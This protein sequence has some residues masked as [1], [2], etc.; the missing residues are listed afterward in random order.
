MST[1]RTESPEKIAKCAEVGRNARRR[2][3]ALAER[4]VEAFN[5]RLRER[6]A[7]AGASASLV[8]NADPPSTAETHRPSQANEG[9]QR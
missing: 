1:A 9:R 4:F 3:D 7:A 8:G 2:H 6:Q 5:A